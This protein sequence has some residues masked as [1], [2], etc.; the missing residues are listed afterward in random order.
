MVFHTSDRYVSDRTLFE[1]LLICAGVMFSVARSR[2]ALP[3]QFFFLVLNGLG[4]LFGT[5]YNINTP[6]LYENNAHHKIGWIATWIMTAQ[7]IMSLLFTYSGRGKGTSNASAEQ[8]AFLPVS[9]ENMS[10]HNVRPYTDY[11]WSGDSGQGTERSSTLN[12]RDISPTDPNRRDTFDEFEK[13]EPQPADTD[14]GDDDE[15]EVAAGSHH[16][17]Q[18]P[19]S[20]WLRISRVDS[21]LSARVPNLLSAKILRVVKVVYDM[22]DK[23]IL[24]LGFI[25]LVSGGVTYAGIFVSRNLVM[26]LRKTWD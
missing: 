7:V 25:A 22:I 2:F 23:T 26:S 20:R 12:S 6:D 13:P 11:R 16:S 8:A 18:S 1:D 5:V 15:D 3:T 19:R 9:V 17:S 14:D 21:F 24:V 4:V 10:Q